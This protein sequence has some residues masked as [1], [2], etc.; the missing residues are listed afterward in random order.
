MRLPATFAMPSKRWISYVL[1]GL[2]FACLGIFAVTGPVI[3]RSLLPLALEIAGIALGLWALW[4]MRRSPPNIIPDVRASAT[5]VRSGPYRWI[6][7]PM[8]SALLL[9]CAAL[10]LDTPSAL[11]LATWL[12]L[13]A[14][15]LTKLRYEERLLHAAFPA[16]AAYAQTSFRLL[17][18]IW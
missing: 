2:Q 13:A 1:V 18:F 8:Y 11:R 4:S 12:L 7:H 9:I 14:T 6:R 17:P 3:A 15:L 10:A 5:L 16:Y